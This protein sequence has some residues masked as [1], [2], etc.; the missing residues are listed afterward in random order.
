[1]ENDQIVEGGDGTRNRHTTVIDE[2]IGAS[3]LDIEMFNHQTMAM[4]E[5]SHFTLLENLNGTHMGEER[6]STINEYT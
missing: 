1:M 5:E 4:F 2:N 3:Y 6:M